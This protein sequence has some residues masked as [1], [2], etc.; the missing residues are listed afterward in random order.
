MALSGLDK[1]EEAL[2][3]IERALRINPNYAEALKARTSLSSKLGFDLDEEEEDEREEEKPEV[4]RSVWTRKEPTSEIMKKTRGQGREQRG[5]RPKRSE[6]TRREPKG[7][8][9]ENKVGRSR[10]NKK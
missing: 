1:D 3:A 5:E 7:E 10:E 8:E 6:W 2:G 4:R 9:T